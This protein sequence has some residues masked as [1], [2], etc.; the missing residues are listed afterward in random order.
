MIT[1]NTRCCPQDRKVKCSWYS[2]LWS[3]K[4]QTR[5]LWVIRTRGTV[6]SPTRRIS[7]QTIWLGQSCTTLNTDNSLICFSSKIGISWILVKFDYDWLIIV[8]CK[9]NHIEWNLLVLVLICFSDSLIRSN[10]GDM[11]SVKS[12][13]KSPSCVNF[14]MTD[15]RQ[16]VPWCILARQFADWSYSCFTVISERHLRLL[17]ISYIT[18]TD[19][20]PP[21]M[22]ELDIWWGA[23]FISYV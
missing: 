11:S 13:W 21:L 2:P 12:I 9:K 19:K 23:E 7:L 8:E 5:N 4:P 10:T 3:Q 14:D 15:R 18:T 16:A 17:L 22:W 20:E 1:A 6:S